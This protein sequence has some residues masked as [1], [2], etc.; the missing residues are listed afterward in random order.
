MEAIMPA[1]AIDLETKE[2]GQIWLLPPYSYSI[3]QIAGELDVGVATVQKWRQQLADNGHQL[4]NDRPE[5]NS[6]S[7]EQK[8]SAV[9]ETALLSEHELAGYCREHGMYVDHVKKWKAVSIAAHTPNQESQYKLDSVRRA[10]KKKIK[11][12]EKELNRKD[13]A[14]A[15]TAALLVLREKYNALWDNSEED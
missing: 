3:R 5:D 15:E 11:L 9:I 7:A 10:D 2:Q 13:K 4:E 12:L 8:F 14:L 1:H 6:F